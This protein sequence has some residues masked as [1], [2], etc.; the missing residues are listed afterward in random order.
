VI[1][2]IIPWNFPFWQALRFA[3]PALTVGN[4]SIL[5]HSNNVPLCYWAIEEVFKLAGFPE[6]SLG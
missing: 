6:M 4:V 2:S 5:R 1:L 3:I